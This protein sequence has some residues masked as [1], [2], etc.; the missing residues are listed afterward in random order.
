[1]GPDCGHGN[2]PQGIMKQLEGILEE[3]T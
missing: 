3:A 2:S 1:V